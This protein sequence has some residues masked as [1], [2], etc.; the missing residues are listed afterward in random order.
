ML[1][2]NC[3]I[4]WNPSKLQEATERAQDK[5][6]PHVGGYL[7]KVARNSMKN[8]SKKSKK[9]GFDAKNNLK[10]PPGT[11]PYSH[12]K[13]SRYDSLRDSIFYSVEDD[14][15]IVGPVLQME[16]VG[17]LHEFGGKSVVRMAPGAA[18]RVFKVG[19]IGPVSLKKYQMS[20][21]SINS[22]GFKDPS[23]GSPVRYIKLRT[24]QQA[25]HATRLNHRIQM[26]YFTKL[27]N[28][29]YPARPF[30]G[31]ALEKTMPRANEMWLDAIKE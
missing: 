2:F 19:D 12:G 30:M 8:V 10:S 16:K 28:A 24:A 9:H 13:G 27:K 1:T 17:K 5:W 31:P 6:L 18:N 7:R 14:A 3:K 25:Q 22:N 26:A 11:P 23:D 15:V 20:G 29:K 21:I 4:N